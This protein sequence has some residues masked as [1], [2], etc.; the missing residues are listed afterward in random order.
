MHHVREIVPTTTARPRTHVSAT[1][2]ATG[3]PPQ[4]QDSVNLAPSEGIHPRWV[5]D[6]EPI[7]NLPGQSVKKS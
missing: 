4:E 2:L 3:R 7:V 6:R 5:R 1:R